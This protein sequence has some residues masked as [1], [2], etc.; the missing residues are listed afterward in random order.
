MLGQMNRCCT[1]SCPEYSCGSWHNNAF[2]RI[3]L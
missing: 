3:V 1:T 2:S